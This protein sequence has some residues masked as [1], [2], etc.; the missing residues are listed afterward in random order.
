M[1]KLIL[2]ALAGMLP[3]M[4]CS[5]KT[6]SKVEKYAIKEGQPITIP[7]EVKTT[8]TGL[9]Y[10]DLKEGDGPVP[11][12]GQTVVVHYTGWLMSGKKFD[13]SVDR[14]KPFKFVL[15]YGQVIPGWD[16]GLSTMHVGGKRRLFIPYQ[17]A[18]G[19]RG[20]PPVIPPKAML[21]FDVELLGV[22]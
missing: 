4:F 8:E 9:K 21:V 15:G 11:Q 3:L 22:E 14:N 18:Y 1:R 10:L 13:S 2:I 20:Y 5:K 16:E 6:D 12:D 17:L 19:E 7:A